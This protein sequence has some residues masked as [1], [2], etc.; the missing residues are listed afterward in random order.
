MLA[1]SAARL[2]PL[3]DELLPELLRVGFR[4]FRVQGSGFR[5]LGLGFRVS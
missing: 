1:G 2:G 5:V 3:L 4:G